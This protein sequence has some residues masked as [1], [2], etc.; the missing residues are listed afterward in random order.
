MAR[1]IGINAPFLDDGLKAK[2]EAEAQAHGFETIYFKDNQEACAGSDGCEVLF[3]SFPTEAIKGDKALKWIHCS[4][5]GVDK[6]VSDD[7]YPNENV[8]VTNSAGG[9]GVTISEHMIA[10][11]LM[12]M[13]RMPEYAE[14][15]AQRG[16]RIIG[17][18]HSIMNSVITIVGMG[19]IGTN[20]ARRVKAMGAACVRG[21]R[22]TDKPG[23][24]CYDEV[25][26]I[27]NLDEAIKGAD[28]VAL[29]V[30]GTDETTHLIDQRRL[31][32][33][34][35]GAYLVNVGRGW[36]I[37]QPALIKALESGKLAGA[38][39]DVTVPEPLPKDDPLWS[40][41][42]ILITP[43]VSGNMSL[44]ITRELVT[45]MFCK[46]IGKYA[47]GE[48]LDNLVDRKAGY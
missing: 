15:T 45:G 32:L 38:A 41:P 39:L 36:A 34:K 2:I 37:D 12:M 7:I 47:R 46:N 11:T 35:D 4:F 28:V 18:I 19:D 30:P 6:V 33:M 23:P 31:S 13:R 5:A 43:H 21:V 26:T 25:Y 17:N 8:I 29:C 20:F 3:G 48:K 44:D 24:D 1:K 27:D 16:W 40:A 42:N 9:Y 14:L 22:R 10:V